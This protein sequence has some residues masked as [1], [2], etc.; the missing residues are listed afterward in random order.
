LPNKLKCK[1]ILR[2]NKQMLNFKFTK[3]MSTI[4]MMLK[5]DKS[6]YSKLKLV[7]KKMNKKHF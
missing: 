6:K 3:Q 7:H 1:M 4:L 2:L 5:I